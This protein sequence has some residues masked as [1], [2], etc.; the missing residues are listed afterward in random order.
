MAGRSTEK[1]ITFLHPFSLS[2]L[3]GV[4]PAGD[5]RV[6]VDEEEV[7]GLSFLVYRRTATM[8]HTPSAGSRSGRHQVF[9]VNPSELEAALDADAD[10]GSGQASP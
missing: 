2:A 8:L 4:Q 6:V 10:A 9:L 7:E 5:Y 1:T 3:D